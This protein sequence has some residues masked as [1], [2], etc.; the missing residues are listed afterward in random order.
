MASGAKEPG[1]H[2]SASGAT[3][4]I[5]PR[6]AA[7]QLPEFTFYVNSLEAKPERAALGD[8]LLEYDTGRPWNYYNGNWYPEPDRLADLKDI[9]EV[10]KEEL[11]KQSVLS[12]EILEYL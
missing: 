8:R 4:A 9:L 2:I 3:S 10:I 7:N 6:V 5:S 11:T 12:D 1:R